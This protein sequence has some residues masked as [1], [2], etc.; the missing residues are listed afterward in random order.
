[1]GLDCVKNIIISN[2]KYCFT[3]AIITLLLLFNLLHHC[4]PVSCL[5]Y[6]FITRSSFHLQWLHLLLSTWTA[7]CVALS[8]AV[9]SDLGESFINEMMRCNAYL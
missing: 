8:V 2:K 1:M 7:I 9:I 6:Y 3:A 4:L 5:L